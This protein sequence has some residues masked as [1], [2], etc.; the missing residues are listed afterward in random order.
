MTT[1]PATPEDVLR[2]K[3]ARERSAREEAEQLL[4]TRSRELFEGGLWLQEAAARLSA[5]EGQLRAILDAAQE[6]IITFDEQGTIFEANSAAAQLFHFQ[7]DEMLG[8]SVG[9]IIPDLKANLSQVLSETRRLEAAGSLAATDTIA[10]TAGAD[11]LPITLSLRAIPPILGLDNR[12]VALVTDRRKESDLEKRLHEIMSQGTG[13]QISPAVRGDFKNRLL[14]KEL[15]RAERR[16]ARDAGHSCYVAVVC[17]NIDR[18]KRV[19]DLLGFDAGDRVLERIGERMEGE[20]KSAHLPEGWQASLCRLSGDE[21]AALVFAPTPFE[22]ME[23]WTRSFA[24]RIG[25]PLEAYDQRFVFSL[26]I[27]VAVSEIHSAEFEA[28]LIQADLALRTVKLRGGN[29]FRLYCSTT[30]H[31]AQRPKATEHNIILGLERHQFFPFFQPKVCGQSGDIKGFE[32]LLRWQHPDRGLIPLGEFLPVLETSSLMLD[33]G[34]QV[35]E[36][37]VQT[38]Q[39]W[40]SVGCR[41]PVSFNVSNGELL[42]QGYRSELIRLMTRYQIDPSLLVLE[43]TENVLSNLGSTGDG[44][45]QELLDAGFKLSVDDFGVGTSSLSRLRSIPLCEIKVDRSFTSGIAHSQRDLDLLKGIVNLGHS[46]GLGVVI[47]GVESELQLTAVQGLGNLTIQ[48]FYFSKAVDNREA[49]ALAQEQPW[50]HHP[51]SVAVAPLQ[52]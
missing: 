5:N 2:R 9:S 15:L 18:F 48:G 13:A 32:A 50:S 29:G 35:F 45:F 52:H 8:L 47:E 51:Q 44:I 38:M 28:L 37:V 6:A 21:F 11:H 43:I 40:A 39:H 26:S 16:A 30:D 17:L 27:G 46:L 14:L 31:D 34:L 19:N 23:A 42:S 24:N 1:A 41:L 7:N 20:L 22:A 33:V 3:L 12:Y 36:R 25:V 49:L 4:D 10:F